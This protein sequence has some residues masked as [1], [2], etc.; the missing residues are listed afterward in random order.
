MSKSKK[1]NKQNTPNRSDRYDWMKDSKGIPA[2]QER[3]IELIL[4]PKQKVEIPL[5]EYRAL[6]EN[7][8]AVKV[9]KKFLGKSHYS[10]EVEDFAKVLF[11][12]EEPKEDPK[13]EDEQNDG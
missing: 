5:A 6:V 4:K 9:F 11:G 8:F 10:H 2:L 7:A 13:K 1:H 12:E 3:S